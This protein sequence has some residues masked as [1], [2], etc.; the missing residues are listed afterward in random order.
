MYDDFVDLRSHDMSG[1]SFWP[2]FTDIMMVVVMI[3][4]LTSTILMVRNWELIDQLRGSLIAEQQASELIK[5]TSQEN[6]T[7]EEQ[8]TNAQNEISIL[9]MQAMQS[10]E[11]NSALSSALEDKEKQIIVIISEKQALD[12]NLRESERQIFN[13]SGQVQ[14]LN[15]DLNSVRDNSTLLAQELKQ[16]RDKIILLNREKESQ[17]TVFANLDTSFKDLK[18]KY[19]KLIKPARTAKGKYV[20]EVQY[21]R[22]DNIERIRYKDAGDTAYR[23]LTQDELK[24]A[25]TKAKKDHPKALYIKMIIPEDSGLSYS[26]AWTFMRGLLEKY[27]YYYQ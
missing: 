11:Q 3:F 23:T 14:Q 15:I 9:R 12:N 13:L 22:V 2:S 21:Q 16:S 1:D 19:D 10:S 25:L 7:L 26:E 24:N 4:L 6:A 17:N 27:D 5:S 20:V 8:L 18:V